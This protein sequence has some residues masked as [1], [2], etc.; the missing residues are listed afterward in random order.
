MP[1]G[2]KPKGPDP[3]DGT[4]DSYR[5]R[6]HPAGQTS[7]GSPSPRAHP[8][9]P[10]PH[11]P[12]GEEDGGA[13]NRLSGG[14]RGPVRPAGRRR[15]ASESVP[16]HTAPDRSFAGPKPPRYVTRRL[17]DAVALAF[18][19]GR[20]PSAWASGP[21]GTI[22]L[23]A[24]YSLLLTPLDDEHGRGLLVPEALMRQLRG[25]SACSDRKD[26][27]LAQFLRD[28]QD[29]LPPG[30]LVVRGHVPPAAGKAGKATAV[31]L[32][33]LPPEVVRAA[34]YDR[35]HFVEEP[36]VDYW[37]G[38]PFNPA[39]D[40]KWERDRAV[41]DAERARAADTPPE[42]VRFIGHLHALPVRAFSARVDRRVQDIVEALN[43]P[44]G[45]V[46]DDPLRRQAQLSGVRQLYSQPFPVYTTVSRT[47][48]LV[49]VGAGLATA[50]G[51]IRRRVLSDCFEVDMASAQL[52]LV[53]S[54]W[55]APAVRDFLAE[56]PSFWD[57]AAAHLQRAL[58]GGTYDPEQ[59]FGL[60]K[61]V[62]KGTVY[63]AA[64]GASGRTLVG[65]GNPALMG[66]GER[67]AWEARRRTVGRLFGA[68][69]EAVGRALLGHPVFRSVLEARRKVLAEIGWAGRSVDV[70]GRA[71]VVGDIVGGRPVTELSAL[72][73]EVQAAEAFVMLRL[74]GLFQAEAERAELASS[75][76]SRRYPE[77][78]LM[79][80][81]ADGAT[82]RVRRARDADLWFGRAAEAL[83]DGCRDL[84]AACGCPTVHT[85]LELKHDPRKN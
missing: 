30:H 23:R 26:V 15:T 39:K 64:Y 82:Y 48:R 51:W 1:T 49:P 34:E 31:A 8:A 16:G 47:Q 44:T 83:Q 35:A 74:G 33:R 40:R 54:L 62:V 77:A 7:E 60:V 27:G 4:T 17:R 2:P 43:D 65:L 29:D 75:A 63:G 55:D 13:P 22:R 18:T 32:R 69:P 79:L 6:P 36:L 56:G 59:D 12:T 53:A 61:G 21:D 46:G 71:Y 73:A 28:L 11:A 78:S 81:Q 57:D 85:R 76:G 24:L 50:P 5:A 41:A 72:A 70:F 3:G 67:A 37:T 9:E 19:L 10:F 38:Q 66:P 68:E 45:P 25:W 84:E 42:V 14:R 80:W 20:L 52:S 58:P